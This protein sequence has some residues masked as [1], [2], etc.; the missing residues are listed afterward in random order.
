MT[1]W[2]F[3]VRALRSRNYR[4]FFGGQ[5]ISLIGTWMTRIATSWLVYRLTDSAVLLG[6]VSFAGQIP[7]F[8]LAPIAGVWVDRWDR[9]HTL[10]VTQVLSMLQSL[11]LAILALARI[12]NIWEI[13]ALALVQG[14][15][16][17]FDMPARQAFV[18]EM[19]EHREDLGNA[20]ALNSSMV[21]A[22][23]LVGPAIAG[24]VIAAANEG[25]CFLV[26]GISY[27]AVIGSLLLMRISG[28]TAR[29]TSQNVLEELKEG[30]A[31]VRDFVPIRSILLLLGFVSLVAMP[32]TVLM[33]IFATSVLHGG[34][35]TLGFLMAA[36]GAGALAG[37]VTLAI[38]KTVLGL[39]R[40]I[41][42]ASALFGGAL[43][44][45]AFS[46]SLWL[47]LVLLAITGY[48]MMQQMAASNTI[49]Q[50]IVDDTKRGR[51]M[52]Y[53]SMAFMGMTPFGSLMAGAIAARAGAPATVV[54]GGALCLAATGWFLREL[55]EIRA[56][57][58]PIY[59]E[60]G[61][62]P[63]LAIGVQQESALQAPPEG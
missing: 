52:A 38:R 23:R 31:Y 39:G 42:V 24:M 55:P 48:G 4:L 30:W 41:V 10:V 13:L 57:V 37:A 7:A 32:Y 14:I 16:N 58:R 1:S 19:V 21:N 28:A 11:A 20:I 49:L 5:S 50:T 53:Y 35:H 44:G 29:S 56:L 12:I 47:S 60:L 36:T 26:D 40:R 2:T 9:H 6:V 45:F 43:I 3:A 62:L 51:V 46:R 18:V 63:H 33:P 27:V 17:A 15:I 8:F 54:I 34:P 61:I 22:A 59:R 25:Y